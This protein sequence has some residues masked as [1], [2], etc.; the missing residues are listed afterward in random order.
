MTK[1]QLEEHGLVLAI[2]A[3]HLAA[4]DSRGNDR[5]RDKGQSD[6]EQMGGGSVVRIIICFL[7]VFVHCM[8]VSTSKIIYYSDGSGHLIA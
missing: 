6:W 5:S 8:N 1:Q 7:C 2:Q 3:A 4:L